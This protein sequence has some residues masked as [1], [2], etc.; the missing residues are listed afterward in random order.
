[1]GDVSLLRSGQLIWSSPLTCSFVAAVISACYSRGRCRYLAR[2]DSGTACLLLIRLW[3]ADW[4]SP[5]A[6]R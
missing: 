3:K 4:W 1:M 2:C 6:S 5:F